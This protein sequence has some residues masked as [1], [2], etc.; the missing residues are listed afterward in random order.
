MGLGGP[1]GGGAGRVCVRPR[2]QVWGWLGLRVWGW[3]NIK[4]GELK[5]R[6]VGGVG[7]MFAVGEEGGL[8]KVSLTAVFLFVLRPVFPFL[9]LKGSSTTDL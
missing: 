6:L 4:G 3:V 9:I 2:V 8:Q 7:G 1:R 5:I